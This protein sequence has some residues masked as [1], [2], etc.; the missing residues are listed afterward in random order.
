MLCLSSIY[1]WRNSP[2]TAKLLILNRHKKFHYCCIQRHPIYM[3]VWMQCRSKCVTTHGLAKRVKRKAAQ[4]YNRYFILQCHILLNWLSLQKSLLCMDTDSWL[5]VSRCVNGWMD[6]LVCAC[7]YV[8]LD[9]KEDCKRSKT[10][11]L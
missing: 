7:A 5:C 3:Y 10:M 1:A 2:Y 4:L 9:T 11:H 8:Q 6:A